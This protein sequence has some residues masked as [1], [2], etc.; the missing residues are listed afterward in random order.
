MSRL[1][2]EL[3]QEQH[4]QLRA[5]AKLH[6][7]TVKDY[8]LHRTLPQLPQN[9]SLPGQET[10]QR[11]EAFLTPRIAEAERAEVAEDSVEQIFA[12]VRQTPDG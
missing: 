12:A 6:G 8:I 4:E 5:L 3:T 7:Q 11:L 10:L 9:E 2:I 1:S